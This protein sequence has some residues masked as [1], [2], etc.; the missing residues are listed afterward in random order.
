[1]LN[2]KLKL[3]K[4]ALDITRMEVLKAGQVLAM[5]QAKPVIAAQKIG[6]PGP[7]LVW[8]EVGNQLQLSWNDSRYR[9]L[10]VSHFGSDQTFLERQLHGG[11][12]QH[13]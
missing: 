4:P 10:T 8:Q 6:D 1:M 2:F 3:L 9:Y 11:K 7:S 13:N 12:A 5:N